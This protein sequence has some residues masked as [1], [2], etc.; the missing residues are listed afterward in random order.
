[1]PYRP[2]Y[3]GVFAPEEQI[4]LIVTKL[5]RHVYTFLVKTP[6][7]LED[8]KTQARIL[9]LPLRAEI[10]QFNCQTLEKEDIPLKNKAGS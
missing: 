3:Q 5:G 2:E 4:L 6:E 1:M 9:A 10:T 8:W 7:E